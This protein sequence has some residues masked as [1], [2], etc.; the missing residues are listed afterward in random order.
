MKLMCPRA[1]CLTESHCDI[2]FLQRCLPC[3]TWSI[4]L[5]E[6]HKMGPLPMTAN[7]FIITHLIPVKK[8][9]C[10][11]HDCHNTDYLS[12]ALALCWL[13]KRSI[14][15]LLGQ[16]DSWS[17]FTKHTSNINSSWRKSCSVVHPRKGGSL[18]QV[19]HNVSFFTIGI[20]PCTIG[21]TIKR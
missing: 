12:M 1:V 3:L 20:R 18:R 15:K 21:S 4:W 14:A 17:Y 9:Q 16:M 5:L 11:Q 13:S 10:T 19:F 7:F 8:H 2:H 6:Y